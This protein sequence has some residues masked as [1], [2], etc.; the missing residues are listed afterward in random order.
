MEQSYTR[1]GDKFLR[2]RS[3]FYA[4]R[5]Q[6][7]PARATTRALKLDAFHVAFML[8]GAADRFRKSLEINENK[9]QHAQHEIGRN[10]SA[11][12]RVNPCSSMFW[13]WRPRPESNRRARIC[14]PLR[15][16]S[17]TWPIGKKGVR[18]PSPI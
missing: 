8:R 15:H 4:E 2:H 6:D 12:F 17:A 7:I 18:R 1:I 9:L 3:C 16:H 14:S 13:E 5:Q 11:Q 10:F